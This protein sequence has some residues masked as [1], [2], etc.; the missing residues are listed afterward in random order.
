[1]EY[2][3][4]RLLQLEY[5]FEAEQEDF[6]TQLGQLIHSESMAKTLSSIFERRSYAKVPLFVTRAMRRKNFIS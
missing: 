6:I 1:M 5:E 4:V 2:C 3:E